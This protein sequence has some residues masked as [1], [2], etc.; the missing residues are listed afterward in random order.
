M[1][2]KV[3]NLMLVGAPGSG[4]GTQAKR[5]LEKYGGREDEK[6]FV[7]PTELYLDPVDGYPV[8]NAVHPNVDGYNQI[9]A[10]VYS[11][12]KWWLREHRDDPSSCPVL[13]R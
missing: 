4:K 6:I 11:W 8:D 2:D 13:E 1:S 7:V 10:S 12:L 9:G 3:H 5:L